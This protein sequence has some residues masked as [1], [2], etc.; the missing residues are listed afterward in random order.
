MGLVIKDGVVLGYAGDVPE[1]LVI[2]NVKAVG[3]GAFKRCKNIRSL[4]VKGP[5]ILYDKAFKGCHKLRKV[6]L[7][8]VQGIGAECFCD[9]G[10]LKEVSLGEQISWIGEQA[11]FG[12]T[13]LKSV[14]IP[15]SMSNVPL[16]MFLKGCRLHR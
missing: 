13:S 15:Y 14:K 8:D 4:I 6:E 9:C 16:G 10:K 1:Q 5:C 7:V 3:R 11:F 2:E 12:C